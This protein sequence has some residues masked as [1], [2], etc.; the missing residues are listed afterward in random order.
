LIALAQIFFF[1]LGGQQPPWVL[2]LKLI[3]TVVIN[4][5][6][7]PTPHSPKEKKVCCRD[8]QIEM[9]MDHLALLLHLKSWTVAAM[10]TG[11]LSYS[12]SKTHHG[13]TIWTFS[14]QKLAET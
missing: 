12:I 9:L 1:T 4:F 14:A 2:V 5:I 10:W 3:N 6:L 11:V 13:L 8:I 7:T